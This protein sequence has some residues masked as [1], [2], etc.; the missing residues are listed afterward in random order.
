M[1]GVQV[2]PRPTLPVQPTATTNVGEGNSESVVPGRYEPNMTPAGTVLPRGQFF[3]VN[4]VTKLQE[5]YVCDGG[6]GVKRTL[7]VIT[8]DLRDTYTF[9]FDGGEYCVTVKQLNRLIVNA[10]K[11]KT[12]SELNKIALQNFL[13]FC[14]GSPSPSTCAVLLEHIMKKML[15]LRALTTVLEHSKLGQLTQNALNNDLLPHGDFMTNWR[16]IG[17]INA[18]SITV[19]QFIPRVLFCC[20]TDHYDHAQLILSDNT[21]IAQR[22]DSALLL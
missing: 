17:L 21:R 12:V 11:A 2:N 7:Q 8:N 16:K 20:T 22:T 14:T 6:D 10:L 1:D 3:D 13:N 19:R 9:L 5:V 18:T 4:P 15:H